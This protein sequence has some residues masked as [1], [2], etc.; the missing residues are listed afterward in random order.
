MCLCVRVFV[1]ALGTTAKGND[2]MTQ[3]AKHYWWHSR[4][5]PHHEAFT[6]LLVTHVSRGLTGDNMTVHSLMKK[7]C[8]KQA[9]PLTF[10]TFSWFAHI[11]LE[12]MHHLIGRPIRKDD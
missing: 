11:S 12:V 3:E 10:S 2:M 9:H 8:T 5:T 6:Q 1:H 4:F 7:M